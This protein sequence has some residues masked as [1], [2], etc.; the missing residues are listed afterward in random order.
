MRITRYETKDYVFEGRKIIDID[1]A[2]GE[3]RQLKKTN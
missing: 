3:G 1:K 2:S